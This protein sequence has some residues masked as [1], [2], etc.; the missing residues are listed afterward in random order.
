[1]REICTCGSVGVPV[2]NHRHYPANFVV[3]PIPVLFQGIRSPEA[4]CLN[5]PPWAGPPL[6]PAPGRA[7]IGG[8]AAAADPAKGQEFRMVTDEPQFRK[9]GWKVTILASVSGALRYRGLMPVRHGVT[10]PPT[11]PRLSGLGISG[12]LA[13]N[14]RD[15]LIEPIGVADRVNRPPWA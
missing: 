1:M 5:R 7:A 15:V 4:S 8:A 12:W 9:T 11:L 6:S 3:R 2:G 10:L 14:P 13:K